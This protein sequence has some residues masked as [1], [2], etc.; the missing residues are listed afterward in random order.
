MAGEFYVSEKVY[1]RCKALASLRSS[2]VMAVSRTM[3]S[4]MP[5]N[6]SM[7]LCYLSRTVD[8]MMETQSTAE[9]G[10][11]Q[12]RPGVSKMRLR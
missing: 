10:R 5:S 8:A 9:A 4:R 2:A 7:Q 1:S 11:I 3:A 12:R 6:T